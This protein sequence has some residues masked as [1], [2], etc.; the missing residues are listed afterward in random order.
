MIVVIAGI[1]RPNVVAGTV[2]IDDTI[3]ERSTASFDILTSEGV[4]FRKGQN[5]VIRDDNNVETKFEGYIDSS[6]E[7]WIS[8]LENYE[9]NLKHSV[10]CTDQHYLADKRSVARA[11]A[12]Q[13][14]GDIV[15]DLVDGFLGNDPILGDFVVSGVQKGEGVTIG[16]VA[17]G[18]IIIQCVFNYI[19]AS[20]AIDALAEECGFWWTI[21]PNKELFFLPRGAE[22]APITLNSENVFDVSVSD[23]NSRYRNRQYVRGGMDITD[24]QTEIQYGDGNKRAYTMSFPL[25]EAPTVEVSVGGGAFTSKTVG[26]GGVDT[27]RQWYWNKEEVVVF[28]EPSHTPLA[29][30][31][32]VRVT[33]RGL[34]EIVVL[35]FDQAQIIERRNVEND[36]TSGFVD[37]VTDDMTINGRDAAFQLAGGLLGTFA[38][39]GRTLKFYTYIDSLKPGQLVTANFPEH[40]VDTEDFLIEKILMEDY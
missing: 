14:A 39:T 16:N 28:Q 30:T 20:Q 29:A 33:Y 15:K 2:Q 18:P 24:P 40:D 32:R 38:R 4:H 35:S 37:E 26:I 10:R 5:V 17:D 25:Y 22:V 21:R 13:T 1:T 12:N 19:P 6:E 31:D 3:F 23:E 8:D 11:Y 34:F 36:N 27:G 9:A 7:V